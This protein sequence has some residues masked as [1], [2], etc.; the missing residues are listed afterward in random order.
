MSYKRL[1]DLN[2]L[3][4]KQSEKLREA[5]AE[6]AFLRYELSKIASCESSHLDDVVSIARAALNR[7]MPLPLTKKN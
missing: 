4:L 1:N 3:Y 2:I 7:K 6:I 5:E